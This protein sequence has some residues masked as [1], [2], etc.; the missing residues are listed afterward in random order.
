M[1]APR[2]GDA[3]CSAAQVHPG[4]PVHRLVSNGG[5]SGARVRA[6]LAQDGYWPL[7]DSVHDPW[8]LSHLLQPNLPTA[9]GHTQLRQSH[10]QVA[11]ARASP[12]A[13]AWLTPLATLSARNSVMNLLQP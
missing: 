2:I 9:P 4:R 8:H 5:A 6:T 7:T 10:V 3:R 12:G 1:I 13:R 11:P